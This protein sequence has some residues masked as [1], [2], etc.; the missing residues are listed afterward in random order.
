MTAI[1]IDWPEIS[2]DPIWDNS[3]DQPFVYPAADDAGEC[4][5][6]SAMGGR[7]LRRTLSG[8]SDNEVVLDSPN[9]LAIRLEEMRTRSYVRVN[10][11]RRHKR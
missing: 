4:D 11:P 1:A 9:S 5:P 8:A 7:L 10:D 2:A 6:P 3:A